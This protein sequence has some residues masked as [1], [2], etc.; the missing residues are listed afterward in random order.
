MIVSNI[1]GGLG[2]QMFQYACGLALAQRSGQPLVLALDMFEGYALHQGFELRRVFAVPQPEAGPEQLR[3]LLGLAA[4]KGARRLLAKLL[5]GPRLGGR[6]WFEPPGGMPLPALLG[7]AGPAYLHGYWQSE[8][9]FED[10]A[11]Q[12]RE[13]LRFSGEP[14]ASLQAW[15][16]ELA[17]GVPVSVHMRRGD[18]VSNARN[19]RIYAECTPSYYRA[20]MDFIEQ[21]EPQAR[22]FVFSDDMAWAREVLAGRPQVQFVDAHRGSASYLDMW[23]MSLCRHHVIAN[24]SFSWWGAWLAQTPQQIVVAPQRWYLQGG[25]EEIVPGRWRRM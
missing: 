25:G 20:A 4:G 15:L 13:Q 9:Y 3:T 18:Y 7:H 2:N 5:P 6:A 21:Q 23:L 8:R 19:R 10:A 16:P 24:S 11:A 12:V 22:F 17:R 1:I 14:P